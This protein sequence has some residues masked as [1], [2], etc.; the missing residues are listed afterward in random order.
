MVAA[1]DVK[2]SCSRLIAHGVNH[3]HIVMLVATWCICGSLEK[4]SRNQEL[5]EL[6]VAKA[7]GHPFQDF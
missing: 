4:I 7:K 1:T 6:V 3:K 2:K 5:L